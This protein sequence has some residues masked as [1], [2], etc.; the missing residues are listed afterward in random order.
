MEKFYH[1][2]MRLSFLWKV[3]ADE[4]VKDLQEKP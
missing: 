4:E 1:Q 3:K 2:Q